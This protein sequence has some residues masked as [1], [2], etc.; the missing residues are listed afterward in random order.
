MADEAARNRVPPTL[1]VAETLEGRA[2]RFNQWVQQYGYYAKPDTLLNPFQSD[3]MRSMQYNT[4]DFA[5][6]A[7]ICK[8]MREANKNQVV[9]LDKPLLKS[10]PRPIVLTRSV[11]HEAFVDSVTKAAMAS[12]FGETSN[13][14]RL[15]AWEGAFAEVAAT[16]MA[17]KTSVAASQDDTFI[18]M[19]DVSKVVYK[20]MGQDVPRFIMDKFMILCKKAEA[21]GRVYWEDFRRLAPRAVQAASADCS[22][23]KELP[24]LVLLMTRTRESDPNLG[25]MGSLKSTYADTFCVD[26]REMLKAYASSLASGEPGRRAILNP[27]AKMLAAG[28]VKG[29]LQIPGFS[30]HVPRNTRNALKVEHSDGR[31][32]HPVV[33][34][35]RMTKKAGGSVLGYAGHM[36]WHAEHEGERL[37]GCDPRTSTGAA[38]GETRLML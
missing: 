14:E 32:L 4:E 5:W 12:N 18:T 20:V 22:L 30:G 13:R 29:T 1:K 17:S 23:K 2:N 25:P 34:S 37:S 6:N 11:S 21:G 27:A 38:F 31:H 35:L 8:T 15:N 16:R 24:P 7:Q 36:P 26:Q 33:N 19:K 28:S 3:A 10:D 9:Q